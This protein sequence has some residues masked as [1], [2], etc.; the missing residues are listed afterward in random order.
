[1]RDD[2]GPVPREERGSGARVEAGG[3]SRVE[4]GTG[5]DGGASPEASSAS[6]R[7]RFVS[8]LGRLMVRSSSLTVGL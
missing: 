3:V 1:M 5:R 6:L 2:V 8:C 7:E 4:P